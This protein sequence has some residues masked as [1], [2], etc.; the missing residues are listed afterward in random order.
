MALYVLFSVPVRWLSIVAYDWLARASVSCEPDGG[1][2]CQFWTN[3][4]SAELLVYVAC[5]LSGW[6]VAR[7]HRPHGVPA[8]CLFSVAVLLWEYAM[9]GLLSRNPPPP[10][11]SVSLTTV[12]MV[13]FVAVLGR[14]LAV[15]IGGLSAA[16]SEHAA[17]PVD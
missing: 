14:P 16:R 6:I 8:V 9:I 11:M 2:W 13:S 7:L 10:E 3:Q 15:L 17:L 12:L 1:F 4:F 5:A